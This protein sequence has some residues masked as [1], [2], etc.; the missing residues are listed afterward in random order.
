MAMMAIESLESKFKSLFESS[1]DGVLIS[2]EG[3][4][5]ISA[6]PAYCSLLGY[7]SQEIT[8]LKRSDVLD[9]KSPATQAV[10]KQ[11]EETGA[12]VGEVMLRRKDGKYIPAEVTSIKLTDAHGVTYISSI[13]RDITD[14]KK[15]E[16]E[17]KA[18]TEELVKNNQ[19]LQQFSFITSHNLRAPVANLMSL[20]SLYN[21]ENPADEFNYM[22]IDKFQESTEQLNSTLN[23]LINILV[24]KSNTNIE[25]EDI[26]FAS[27]LEEVK[28]NVNNLLEQ[29]QGSITSDFSEV[30]G[31]KYNRIHIESLFLNMITNAI[32]YRSPD[33]PP[34][35]EVK[36]YNEG[37]WV[38]ITFADNGLGMDL[39]R[40][41]DRLFGLY[42]RFHE[43]KEGKGLGLYMTR[44]QVLAMGGKIEVDSQLGKG[45]TFKVY[46]KKEQQ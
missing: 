32:R 35:I 46:F 6:N 21:K 9:M 27:V 39:K 34:A 3:G 13:V 15:I 43:N 44:S 7:D 31:I 17:Q 41:G 36:S 29:E 28:K 8:S 19:D 10:L 37:E 25:K 5:F 38:V 18:L 45:T 33:R 11:R 40:Y 20:L 24:I 4:D 42:Q 1:I 22:L 14:K 2:N 30:A 16:A 23:D 12:F 26:C